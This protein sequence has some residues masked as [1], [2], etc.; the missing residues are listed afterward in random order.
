MRLIVPQWYGMASVKWIKQIQVIN[1]TFTGPFQTSDYMYY[2]NKET[3]K[4]AFP[5]TTLNVNSTI[6][7]PLN[8]DILNT[9]KHLIKGIAWT[10][11][12]SIT[13]VEISV[14][15]GSSWKSAV[16]NHAD[17]TGYQWVSW[18]YEWAVEE[19]GEYT[20]IS[21]AT[22]SANRI[23]PSTPFWNRKGYGFNASDIAKVKIE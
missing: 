21:K 10:G 23:Q 13:K 8:M 3:D 19:K 9:G 5:V 18:S 22:D 17:H 7:K 15:N 6:Q 4:D 11:K 16:V 20:L 12:G 1:S 2:P 14:N